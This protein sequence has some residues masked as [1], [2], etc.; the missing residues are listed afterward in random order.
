MGRL[1]DAVKTRIR[2]SG[3]AF[4]DG[5]TSEL[6][7]ALS[8]AESRATLETL[9]RWTQI[10]GKTRLALTL[11]LNH[12]WHVPLYLS[13]R[14]FGT[15]PIPYG[16]RSFE[17]EFDFLAQQLLIRT[18]DDE[19]ASVELEARSVADFFHA[20][21]AALA[22]LDIQVRIWPVPVETPDRT[23]FTSDQQHRTYEGAF[24][25]TFWQILRQTDRVLQQFRGSFLGKCSP[26]HFFWGSFDL[27]H[28]R[29]SGRRAPRHAGGIPNT[30]DLVTREAYS[31]E[32]WSCGFWNGNDAVPHPAFYAYAYPAPAGFAKARVQPSAAFFNHEL[33]E[34]I[35]PYDAVR[36]A[37]RPEDTLLRFV[38]QTYE[39]AADSGEWNRRELE[40]I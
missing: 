30:P 7:P 11:P 19:V 6:W 14:G 28:T 37:K 29:F 27:A 40:R 33:R 22:A 39:A 36:S 32:C 38:Q 24:A 16:G 13:A 1:V 20:Y 10:V 9:H 25:R 26:I 3:V 17:V 21:S 34:F 12:W 15:S 23:P 4:G 8:Y 2:R 31:H 18:S 35:L 5:S